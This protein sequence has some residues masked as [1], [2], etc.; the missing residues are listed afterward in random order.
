MNLFN[1]LLYLVYF[2]SS[3]YASAGPSD[4]QPLASSSS[5]TGEL[6]IEESVRLGQLIIKG[7]DPQALADLLANRRISHNPQVQE[8]LES[9]VKLDR[10]K[11]FS[12]L[13]PKVTNKDRFDVVDLLDVALQEHRPEM[14]HLLLV[15]DHDS[16]EFL[17]NNENFQQLTGFWDKHP[18]MWTEG[19]LED[20]IDDNPDLVEAM[21][22][23]ADFLFN[24]SR[25]LE[26]TLMAIR[27]TRRFGLDDYPEQGYDP[28]DMLRAA[29]DSDFSDKYLAETIKC[30]IEL[31]SDVTEEMRNTF[32]LSHPDHIHSR[33]ALND[34]FNA[35][36]GAMYLEQLIVEGED[37]PQMVAT[38]LERHP[39]RVSRY[40][41]E[42]LC[43]AIKYGRARSFEVLL[44]YLK[45]FPEINYNQTM[46]NLFIRSLLQHQPEI[47]HIL[48]VHGFDLEHEPD[49][50]VL[51][52]FWSRLPFLWE[53][54]ELLGLIS[55]APAQMAG[56]FCHLPTFM[57]S[58]KAVT[59][60]IKVNYRY[61]AARGDDYQQPTRMLQSVISLNLPDQE[62]AM[63]IRQLVELGADVTEEMRSQFFQNRPWY[64]QVLK[65]L[66]DALSIPDVK[67][68]EE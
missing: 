27:L 48:L 19:E 13:F 36:A 62:F 47:C 5:D 58:P 50:F 60:M 7:D 43:K 38:F 40:V 33:L 12:Y 25:G 49:E 15:E 35:Y 34:G 22:L 41:P 51:T 16:Y 6:S 9:M 10:T 17:L 59:M 37:A 53:E 30:L 42:L 61:G 24:E 31:G 26:T 65:A 56:Q 54:N 20:L 52:D 4:E 23:T 32:W 68:V 29:L 3:T 8:H 46:T 2:L 57:H 67:E 11:S 55:C 44:D 18:F 39:F 21:C 14:C 28:A 45:S 63:I 64:V 1:C 66:D